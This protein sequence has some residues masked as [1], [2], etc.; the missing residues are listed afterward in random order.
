[1]L[2][3][4]VPCAPE[5]PNRRGATARY[6]QQAVL[7]R[8]RVGLEQH[9]AVPRT[10]GGDVRLV[11]GGVEE[12]PVDDLR[13]IEFPLTEHQQRVGWHRGIGDELAHRLAQPGGRDHLAL[14][15]GEGREGPHRL[16]VG[17]ADGE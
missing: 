1:M 12:P 7:F 11:V 17:G 13:G 9:G 3:F 15:H 16:G 6:P 5:G 4:T 8:E 2:S 10:D 14:G